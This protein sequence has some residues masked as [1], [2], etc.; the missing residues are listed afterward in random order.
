MAGS[1]PPRFLER[2]RLEA[3]RRRLSLRTEE[4]YVGWVRRFILFHGKRHPNEMGASEVIA[5]L[6]HLTVERRVSPSTQNQAFSALVFLFRRVLDRELEGL[7]GAVRAREPAR[8]PV[9]LTRDEVRAVL[10]KL[11]G[12]KRLQATLL[13]GGGLRLLELLRLRVKDVDLERRQLSI[14]EPKGGRERMTPMPRRAVES[15]SAHL[16]EVKRIWRR[17]RAAGAGH[18]LLPWALGRKYPGASTEWGWQ[19]VFPAA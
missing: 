8:I 1:R 5:F 12:T 18:V 15:L 14:R 19:W 6:T 16:A 2:V 3:R 11:Q 10:T 13:Y 7:D 4:A 9:V 17:D